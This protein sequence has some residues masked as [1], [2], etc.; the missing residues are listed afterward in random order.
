[1]SIQ[2]V[3]YTALILVFV[4][5]W[6]LPWKERDVVILLSFQ[7]LSAVILLL[8]SRPQEIGGRSCIVYFQRTV[9]SFV[10]Y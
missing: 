3:S 5:L 9:F 7:F 10:R 8:V 4:F 6:C 1:M 2:C